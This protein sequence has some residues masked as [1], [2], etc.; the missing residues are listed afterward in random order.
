MSASQ[1]KAGRPVVEGQGLLPRIDGVAGLAILAQAPKVRVFP[2]V[3]AGAGSRY[4]AK[5]PAGPVAPRAG[6]FGMATQQ[7]VVG[8]LVIENHFRKAHQRETPPVMLAVAGLAGLGPGARLSVK[9]QSTTHVGTDSR[10]AR[11]AFSVLRLAGKGFVARRAIGLEPGVRVTQRTRRDQP[12]HY[13]L[14]KCQMRGQ[15]KPANGK[16]A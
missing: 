1:R 8:Q 5:V 7:R 12:F 11:K 13:A 16:K 6:R 2:G 9:A 15:C 14:R 4:A 10:V 3:A